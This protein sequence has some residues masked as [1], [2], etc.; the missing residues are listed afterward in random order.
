MTIL[1]PLEATPAVR[2]AVMAPPQGLVLEEELVLVKA[3][4]VGLL[5]GQLELE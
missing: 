5:I 4:V 1:I 2:L 3:V